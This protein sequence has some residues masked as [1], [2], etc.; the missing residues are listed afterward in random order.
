MTTK[1]QLKEKEI[2]SIIDRFLVEAKD[3]YGNER[4][5]ER[6]NQD[7]H[8]AAAEILSLLDHTITSVLEEV[9]RRMPEESDTAETIIGNV[10]FDNGFNSARQQ[11]LT[12]INEIKEE[13]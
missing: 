5:L 8:L 9:E 1:E 13:K 2:Y 6:L 10:C 3:Q 12:I 4:T 11:V 7:R